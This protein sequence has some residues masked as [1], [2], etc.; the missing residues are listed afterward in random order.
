[1]V[2]PEDIRAEA[3]LKEGAKFAVFATRDSVLLKKLEIPDAKKAFE[4]ISKFA[5]KQAKL[6]G[7][8][9]KDVAKLVS[10][11]RGVKP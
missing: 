10:A 4:E 3:G 9:Q 7:L 11:G 1:V 8:K 5:F 2:I 6:K